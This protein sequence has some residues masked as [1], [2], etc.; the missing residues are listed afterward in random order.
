[1]RRR[2]AGL[3]LLSALVMALTLFASAASAVT[4]PV[5]VAS[6]LDNPRHLSF[7]A[8]GDLYVA[9]AGR[10]GAGPCAS[11]P[12]GLFCFGTSGAV[13]E[14]NDTGADPRVLTGLPSIAIAGGEVLGPSD[15]AFT[16]SQKFVL[17]IGI[18]GSATFRSAFG[19]RRSAA[20]DARHRQA[21][22][23]RSLAAW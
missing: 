16:G 19:P 3:G 22:G 8:D 21:E 20:R 12:L 10:G 2:V 18:G 4:T 5:V 1:M 11:H 7:S 14:V 23:Q 15:I 13:T 9:E 17:S 6:G